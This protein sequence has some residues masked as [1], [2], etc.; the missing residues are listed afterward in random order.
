MAEHLN[1]RLQTSQNKNWD[2]IFLIKNI[3]FMIIGIK[4]V[5]KWFITK[6]NSVS[7]G[8]NSNI[9][10]N[11]DYFIGR[12]LKN[13]VNIIKYETSRFSLDKIEQLRDSSVQ[14]LMYTIDQ[15]E[16]KNKFDSFMNIGNKI[17]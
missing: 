11:F 7:H 10:K 14:T 6:N 8:F 9:F 17:E 13:C 1:T 4:F 12:K 3:D 2:S 15:S 16:I 5:K